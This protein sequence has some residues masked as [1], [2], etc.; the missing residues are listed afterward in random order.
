MLPAGFS[1]VIALGA[2]VLR[3][4]QLALLGAVESCYGATQA[5]GNNG[6]QRI[7]VQF[8]AL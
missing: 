3:L 1:V 4:H 5:I 7:V 2:G 8:F 6:F